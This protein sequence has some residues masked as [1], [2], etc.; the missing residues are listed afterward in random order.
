MCSQY[1]D[2]TNTT[3][4]CLNN[5]TDNAFYQVQAAGYRTFAD[6]GVSVASS[7]GPSY[8]Q[9]DAIWLMVGHA[10]A[11]EITTYTG[12]TE[13]Y[14]TAAAGGRYSCTAPNACLNN[15][16]SSQIHGIKIMIFAGCY[17]SNAS[18][19]TGYRLP[20]V[21]VSKGVDSAIGWSGL[22]DNLHV[23]TWTRNFFYYPGKGVL[24]A[25]IYAEQQVLAQMGGYGGTNNS[26]IYGSTTVSVFPPG[27][28]S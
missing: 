9:S 20:A 6:I 16:T 3:P 24:N 25:A 26:V 15:Y 12:T 11:G 19:Q 14:M 18:S 23:P 28:G 8:A 5:L 7:M 22:L 27:Y 17:T 13:T 4:S 1:P 2:G 10:N 21:A